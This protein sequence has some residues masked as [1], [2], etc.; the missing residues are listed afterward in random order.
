MVD[1]SGRHAIDRSAVL[2]QGDLILRYQAGN[3]AAGPAPQMRRRL[4]LL[5]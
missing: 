4:A 3:Y 2:L 1:E 5:P